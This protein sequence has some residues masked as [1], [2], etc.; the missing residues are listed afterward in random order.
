MKVKGIDLK[1]SQHIQ[2]FVIVLTRDVN[3][4]YCDDHFVIHMNTESLWY[5]FETNISI[6]PQKF[7]K[8][9]MENTHLAVWAQDEI[10]TYEH[11]FSTGDAQQW[12]SFFLFC[13]V[14]DYY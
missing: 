13:A 14:F 5:T 11:C 12:V 3:C 9:W 4:N 7:F 6:T 8:M 2:K 1:S 10:K